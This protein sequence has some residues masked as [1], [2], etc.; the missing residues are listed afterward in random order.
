MSSPPPSRAKAL[1]TR[2]LTWHLPV[3]A[4]VAAWAAVSTQVKDPYMD[5]PFHAPQ[6]RAYCAGNWDTWDPKLTTPPGLYLVSLAILRPLALLLRAIPPTML[7]SALQ[8]GPPATATEV[9]PP[10]LCTLPMLRL[11]STLLSILLLS[12]CM[13]TVRDVSREQQVD[14]ALAQLASP[15]SAKSA[16]STS[17][18]QSDDQLKQIMTSASSGPLSLSPALA[19][20][21]ALNAWLH[22]IAVFFYAMYY[23]DTASSVLVL[24][25]YLLARRRWYWL[26][27]LVGLA[28]ILVR[29]TNAIWLCFSAGVT[30]VARIRHAEAR[31]LLLSQPHA[32]PAWVLGTCPEYTF[33]AWLADHLALVRAVVSRYRAKSFRVLA[34]ATLALGVAAAAARA[35]GGLL[36]GDKDNHKL[37]VH[38]PQ[39]MYCTVAVFALCLPIVVTLADL[40]AYVV[41]TLRKLRSRRGFSVMFVVFS[42]MLLAVHFLSYTHPFLLADNRHVTFYLWKNVMRAHWAA[43][44]LLVPVYF[45]A[46]W[47]L[48]RRMGMDQGS[49][50]ISVYATA[51]ALT[52]V[53]S[54]LV[55]VRY[56]ILP[57]L[58]YRLHCVERKPWKLAVESALH[59]VVAGVAWWVFLDEEKWG[60]EWASEPGVR[61]RFMW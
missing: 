42:L 61:M 34:P 22:P 2:I 47:F 39:V 35:N 46:G 56:F 26:S 28:S 19:A 15:T 16:S 54:P 37:A 27:G 23:T 21:N 3:L 31:R 4:I 49:L 1:A 52:L 18:I 5:E 44:Y 41:F 60:F 14:T 20:W 24:A 9:I 48:Y 17:K 45:M 11:T 32:L 13:A 53:P 36:A 38:V 29:Q 50:F 59:L 51:V 40:S 33:A 30:L 55:E 57:A 10:A 25:A 8:L 58:M 12:L 43:K 6:A 7:P